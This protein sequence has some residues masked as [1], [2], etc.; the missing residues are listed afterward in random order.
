MSK[1][2]KIF[3]LMTWNKHTAYNFGYISTF[4]W[5]DQKNLTLKKRLDSELGKS[6]RIFQVEILA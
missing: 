3:Q 1:Q 5:T 6:V 4:H 2:M